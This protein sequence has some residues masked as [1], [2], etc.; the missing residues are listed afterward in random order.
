MTAAC[1]P[2]VSDGSPAGH[3]NRALALGLR[4]TS[5]GS[6]PR[7]LAGK[8]HLDWTC[9]CTSR[10]NDHGRRYRTTRTNEP[11]VMWEPYDASPDELRKVFDAAEADGLE[12]SLS[13]LSPWNPGHTF[14]LLFR[15][16]ED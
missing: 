5:T 13:G 12:V 4:L 1:Y 2:D 14:A 15:A 10:L 6:C 3:K 16:E 8:P 9:W 11:V 7:R